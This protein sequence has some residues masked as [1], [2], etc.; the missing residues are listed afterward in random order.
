M[1]NL[2]A[3]LHVLLPAKHNGITYYALALPLVYVFLSLQL[4]ILTSIMIAEAA[5][6]DK[7]GFRRESALDPLYKTPLESLAAEPLARKLSPLVLQCTLSKRASSRHICCLGSKKQPPWPPPPITLSKNSVVASTNTISTRKRPAVSQ[8]GQQAHP[9]L[10]VRCQRTVD[11]ALSSQLSSRREM[12]TS[13]RVR[14]LQPTIHAVQKRL[15]IDSL[16]V[17]TDAPHLRG[18]ESSSCR[19]MEFARCL[20]ALH[21]R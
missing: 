10:Q 21:I 15:S 8:L 14:G 3:V 4:Y 6:Q 13:L 19:M 12:L 17:I 20:K 1:G 11:H 7:A 16:L 18:E 2:L 5:L 9:V